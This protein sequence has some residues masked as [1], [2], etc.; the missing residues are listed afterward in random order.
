MSIF[1]LTF[2]GKE[3]SW[4][5]LREAGDPGAE[6]TESQQGKRHG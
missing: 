6:E 1:F 5:R 3:D 2:K 4:Q